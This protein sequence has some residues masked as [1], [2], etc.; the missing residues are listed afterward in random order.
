M[1]AMEPTDD[2]ALPCAPAARIVVVDDDPA[3]QDLMYEILAEAGWVALGCEDGDRAVETIKET[4]PD[5]ILLDIHL[6]RLDQ[7][8]DILTYLLLHPF[9]HRI[10]VVI[11]SAAQREINRRADWLAGRGIAVVHKPFELDTLYHE[12]T[13]ALA[14]GEVH[15]EALAALG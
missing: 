5:A 12:V 4:R 9:L 11:C 6:A 10:P 15:N 8:W 1:S 2:T 3:F 13:A 7:G 14:R